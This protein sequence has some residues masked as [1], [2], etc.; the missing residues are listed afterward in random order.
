MLPRP[1]LLLLLLPLLGRAQSASC[2]SCAGQLAAL[3]PLPQSYACAAASANAVCA[4]CSTAAAG[5]CDVSSS[6]KPFETVTTLPQQCPAPL[7]AAAVVPQRSRTAA[8]VGV[9]LGAALLLGALLYSNVERVEGAPPPSPPP[10]LALHALFAA[11]AC[12]WVAA[13]CLLAAPTVPWLFAAAAD[14]SSATT[15]TLFS[16]QQCTIMGGA[17]SCAIDAPFSD[18]FVANAAQPATLLLLSA[19]NSA[20]VCGACAGE[21]PRGEERR[22]ALSRAPFHVPLSLL[23]SRSLRF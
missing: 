23:P 7:A 21:G 5:R 6:C 14:G 8:L 17:L 12:L 3:P 10:R 11:A 15:L 19:A 1:A 9:G 16:V 20:G 4:W 13:S 18:Y 22:R 2:A